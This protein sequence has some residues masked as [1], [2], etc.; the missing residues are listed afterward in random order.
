[1]QTQRVLQGS[2]ATIKGNAASL[3]VNV[4]QP[5]SQIA[6]TTQSYKIY[7]I[8]ATHAVQ[9]G[10]KIFVTTG[11]DALAFLDARKAAASKH[12]SRRGRQDLRPG[13]A[14]ERVHRGP[15]DS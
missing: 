12:S 10:N 1:M 4:L 9:A 15:Q 13:A 3:L 6:T 2:A 7:C 5:V 8:L 14:R 11:L